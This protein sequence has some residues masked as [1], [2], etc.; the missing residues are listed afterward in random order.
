MISAC[1]P[2]GAGT[3][4]RRLAA[5]WTRPAVALW[6]WDTSVVMYCL[7]QHRGMNDGIWACVCE[8]VWVLWYRWQAVMKLVGD[9]WYLFSCSFL[10]SISLSLLFS[11][12]LSPP[13]PPSLLFFRSPIPSAISL[14]HSLQIAERN[15]YWAVFPCPAM[16]FQLWALRT[17]SAAS[18]PLRYASLCST[19]NTVLICMSFSYFQVKTQNKGSFFLKWRKAVQ[20]DHLQ[21]IKAAKRVDITQLEVL[22][23]LKAWRFVS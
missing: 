12:W 5:S 1:K 20:I 15:R 8:C 21:P 6:H 2:D 10:P 18:M 16:S 13:L 19:D 22:F 11:P 14:F 17:T 4:Q 23:Y 3:E 9:E 7:A